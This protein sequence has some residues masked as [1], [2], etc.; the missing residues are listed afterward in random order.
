MIW[1]EWEDD[2][3]RKDL[4]P[5]VSTRRVDEFGEDC[6]HQNDGDDDYDSDYGECHCRDKK[7]TVEK[8]SF[9]VFRAITLLFHRRNIFPT[10]DKASL[11]P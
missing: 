4:A 3:Y 11:L 10:G 2:D 9:E 5:T 8:D 6:N 7:F 1:P